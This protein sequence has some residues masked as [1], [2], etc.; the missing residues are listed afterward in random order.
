[1]IAEFD[2]E[3]VQIREIHAGGGYLTQ[4]SSGLI[5]KK[6]EGNGSIK[7]IW[8]DGKTGFRKIDSAESEVEFTEPE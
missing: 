1:M 7:V 8:P 6:P 2:D 5:L 4:D 3:K